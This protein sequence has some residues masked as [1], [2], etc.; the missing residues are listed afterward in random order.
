M[1]TP[2][3]LKP[4]ID[5]LHANPLPVSNYRQ[6]SSATKQSVFG[7]ASRRGQPA[8]YSK[9]CASHPATY[10]LLLDLANSLKLP[11][12]SSILVSQGVPHNIKVKHASGV[13]SIIT[14]DA[15]GQGGTLIH[16]EAPSIKIGE[17]TAHTIFVFYTAPNSSW[18]PAPD[19]VLHDGR[20]VFKKGDELIVPGLRR[21]KKC[22]MGM[23]VERKEVHIYF[24]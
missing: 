10:K 15:D 11:L 12:F 9:L 19:V 7:V 13:A 14:C 17:P 3:H 23:W 24:P 22:T 18:L 5:E 21:S 8:D 20:L 1:L 4:I 6:R 16:S 2:E